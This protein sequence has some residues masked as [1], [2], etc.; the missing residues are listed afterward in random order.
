MSIITSYDV[1]SDETIGRTDPG[2]GN[3]IA[4]NG[5]RGVEI[6]FGNGNTVRGNDIFDNGGLG[7]ITN[8]NGALS[9]YAEDRGVTLTQPVPVLNSAVFDL[10]GTVVS[11]SLTGTPFTRYEIDF[12]ANDA[13]NPTGF[14]DGQT[15]L[16][17]ISVLVDDT[18]SVQFQIPLDD[19]VP[20]GQWITATATPDTPDGNTSMFS[21]PAPVIAADP[22]TIQFSSPKYQVTETGGAAVMVVTR[23]GSTGGT[24]T[25][26]YAT[27]DDSA[28][29]GTNY[30]AESGTLTFAVADASETI[31][32][33]VQDDGLADGDK[34]FQILLS[35]PNGAT[36]GAVTEADVTLADSDAAGQLQFSS[37]AYPT[38]DRALAAPLFTVTRTGGSQGTVMV[39]YRVTGGTAIGVSALPQSGQPLGGDYLD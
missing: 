36:L 10:Q 13:V 38:V 6:P 9:T 31:A 8:I 16:Q 32:I 24:A 29:A 18:G 33:P 7:L 30:T 35:N 22:E 11:G 15:Y 34:G 12:F 25:V 2:A 28:L 23:S 17:S 39:D 21:Q 27:S 4:F 3:V 5:G 26:D 14:G 1:A 19:A 37:A 20:I